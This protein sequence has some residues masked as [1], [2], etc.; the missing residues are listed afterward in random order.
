V[1]HL[2]R[3]A[4]S[5]I[6]L[7]FWLAAAAVTAY[8][9]LTRSDLDAVMIVLAAVALTGSL[10]GAVE[11]AA[12][13]DKAMLVRA[14]AASRPAD[15]ELVRLVLPCAQETGPSARSGA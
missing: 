3:T 10:C 5:R 13:R 9:A 12:G 11:A 15:G 1:G 2:V 4:L 8:D 14:L 6:S 7:L